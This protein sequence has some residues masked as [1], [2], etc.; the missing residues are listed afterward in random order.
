MIRVF[1]AICSKLSKFYS[2]YLSFI[3][4]S[5]FPLIP[6]KMRKWNLL[7]PEQ[8][9]GDSVPGAFKMDYL[10]P[11]E[12]TLL[13]KSS[14]FW[15]SYWVTNFLYSLQKWEN[16][17]LPIWVRHRALRQS[18]WTIRSL[19]RQFCYEIFPN[20]YFHIPKEPIV[21]AFPWKMRLRKCIF[22][23]LS[24]ALFGLVRFSLGLETLMF[25]PAVRRSTCGSFFPD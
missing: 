4:Q 5:R 25:L 21:H 22:S 11:V 17:I 1:W 7:Q 15:Q 8:D 18:N 16:E 9:T 14:F 12:P 2:E 6:R 24:R 19:P 10:Q 23:N 20:F 13:R 3:L